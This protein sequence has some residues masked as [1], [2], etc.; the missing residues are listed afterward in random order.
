[1]RNQAAMGMETGRDAHE[2]SNKYMEEAVSS[3]RDKTPENTTNYLELLEAYNLLINK[4]SDQRLLASNALFTTQKLIDEANAQEQRSL[5][6]TF[7]AQQIDSLYKSDSA[8]KLVEVL[9]DERNR[10]LI[11]EDN[12]SFDLKLNDLSLANVIENQLRKQGERLSNLQTEEVE[13]ERD[14]KLKAEAVSNTKKKKELEVLN[15][16]LKE[17][18]TGLRS[19]HEEISQVDQQL[20][21]LAKDEQALRTS[22]ELYEIFEEMEASRPGGRVA[23]DLQAM[24]DLKEMVEHNGEIIS[25]L[26]RSDELVLAQTSE[27]TIATRNDITILPGVQKKATELDIVLKEANAQEEEYKL[28]MKSLGEAE[29]GKEVKVNLLAKQNIEIAKEQ[30]KVLRAAK[31]NNSQ[32]SAQIEADID[33]WENLLTTFKK[34]AAV[35]ENDPLAFEP[36]DEST[37]LEILLNIDPESAAKYKMT[38]NSMEAELMSASDRYEWANDMRK[39]IKTQIKAN[40]SAMLDSDDLAEL[41]SLALETKN[42]MAALD[43]V[44]R[45]AVSVADLQ[46]AYESDKKAIMESDR[47]YEDKLEE[48]IRLTEEFIAQ[49]AVMKANPFYHKDKSQLDLMANQASSKLES[50]QSDL[51]LTLNA[52]AE[53]V[54]ESSTNTEADSIYNELK[55]LAETKDILA[56]PEVN[57]EKEIYAAIAPQYLTQKQAIEEM[58]TEEQLLEQTAQLSALDQQMVVILKNQTELRVSEM[59]QTTDLAVKDLLQLE[60]QRLQLATE[61]LENKSVEASSSNLADS[62]TNNVST[63]ALETIETPEVTEMGVKENP[64]S[65][66]AIDH[67]IDLIPAENLMTKKELEDVTTF[68]G[69]PENISSDQQ[70]E[71]SELLAVKNYTDET[72]LSDFGSVSMMMVAMDDADDFDKDLD[73][74]NAKTDEIDLLSVE[75][76]LEDKRSRQKKIEKQIEKAYYY[77]AKAEIRNSKRIAASAE[78]L[79][80]AQK[81]ELEKL[82]VDHQ[83]DL[84]SNPWLKSY[85]FE[86]IKESKEKS[87]QADQIRLTVAPEID[88][89]KQ[90]FGMNRAAQFE[91]EAVESNQKAI[92]VLSQTKEF[93]VLD[94][95]V[96]AALFNNVPVESRFVTESETEN[97]EIADNHVITY[98]FILPEAYI[99]AEKISISSF[100]EDLMKDYSL[101][102][103]YAE[104]VLQSPQFQNASALM[105]K[106]D[107]IESQLLTNIEDYN[108]IITEAAELNEHAQLLETA[109]DSADSKAEAEGLEV[110]RESVLTNL[111]VLVETLN[112]KSQA[113]STLSEDL[114]AQN[115]EVVLALNDLNVEETL[116]EIDETIAFDNSPN[117]LISEPIETINPVLDPDLTETVDPVETITNVEAPIIPEVEAASESIFKS[118]DIQYNFAANNNFTN[119]IKSY[120]SELKEEVFAVTK[121][122]I[123]S[124]SQPV[125]LNLEMPSGIIYK[126]QVGAFR[127]AIATKTFGKFAPLSGEQLN[128]GITRYTAGLFKQFNSAEEAKKVIREMGYSDAFVVAFEDGKRIPLYEAKKVL[129]AVANSSSVETVETTLDAQAD[130]VNSTIENSPTQD[131]TPINPR[132]VE[133]KTKVDA[134]DWATQS[135]I[136]F[137]VQIGVFSKQVSKEDLFN[138]ENVY[139][140][141]VANGQIRYTSG[142][143]E[144]IDQASTWKNQMVEKGIQDAFI[145]AYQN[146]NRITISQALGNEPISGDP[147][148][149]PEQ[150]EEK[151]FYQ[152][153]IGVYSSE[154]PSKTALAMLNLETRWGIVQQPTVDG[155]MYVTKLVSSM[156]LVK[157]IQQEFKNQGVKVLEAIT[158]E[159]GE[160]MGSQPLEND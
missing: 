4:S 95:E 24:Q 142:R 127:N 61:S 6:T 134:T 59:D 32:E 34:D 41:E 153:V 150:P 20:T 121:K 13:F 91:L 118:S 129:A 26:S 55:A 135:G 68:D 60:V 110:E 38:R 56:I 151:L 106:R 94:N 57:S 2:L 62:E 18:K 51:D 29:V 71:W 54:D 114:N 96:L 119:Y 69:Y 104:A 97:I 30:L 147:I 1:M 145:S 74:V 133:V 67:P 154:V 10:R 27:E 130:V 108:E 105:A 17:L 79:Y 128:N 111:E 73:I 45:D 77:K 63:V 157:M 148:T 149:E 28:A 76:Q 109:I 9:T 139:S 48:Q 47:V 80:D 146:G 102:N 89:I 112:E 33:A 53:T 16:E 160:R 7:R 78:V 75:Q 65:N 107:E 117:P 86:L 40:E 3:L 92:D 42:Y 115:D 126:V 100:K 39:A 82:L 131:P 120:P 36:V 159:N 138:A 103:E 12:V 152:V 122:S 22:A 132:P 64:S 21:V 23:P 90:A 101:P 141:K 88:E 8:D 81:K 19:V 156:G 143:F 15:V 98:K 137:T 44:N 93:A 87:E 31:P 83:E 155:T 50:Y 84:V 124:E 125:P 66:V 72:K 158:Y 136:F 52:S 123:Y 116:E 25:M 37:A 140:E 70:A 99:G 35:A 144:S 113:I 49:T 11:G 43:W 5:E 58:V 14:I 85:L 46:M